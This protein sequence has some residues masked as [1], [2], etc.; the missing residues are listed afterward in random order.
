MFPRRITRAKKTVGTTSINSGNPL[1]R[2]LEHLYIALP[3]G[4]FD[5]VKNRF[6]SNPASA[7]VKAVTKDGIMRDYDGVNVSYD[8]IESK[9]RSVH[10]FGGIFILDTL[11]AGNDYTAL[12]NSIDSNPFSRIYTHPS[13][14]TRVGFFYRAESTGNSAITYSTANTGTGSTFIYTGAFDGANLSGKYNNE[15]IVTAST[16]DSAFNIDRVGFGGLQR[17]SPAVPLDCKVS[18]VWLYD[19][20][21]SDAELRSLHA[22]PYQLLQPRTQLLPLTTGAAPVGINIFRRRMLMRKAA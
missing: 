13:D 11:D 10:S 19:R 5:L 6:I 18:L 20:K 22:N 1:A 9:D 21:L 7:E 12:G 14:G 3:S 16:T 4:M 8:V 2:G 15:T 17:I